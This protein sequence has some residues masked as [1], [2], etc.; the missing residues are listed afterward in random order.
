MWLQIARKAVMMAL[1]TSIVQKYN[2]C[3]MLASVFIHSI[4]HRRYFLFAKIVISAFGC[5]FN[6]SMQ[7]LNSHNGEGGVANEVSNKDLLHRS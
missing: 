3:S 2:Q 6:G 5:E 4:K 1:P 7:H